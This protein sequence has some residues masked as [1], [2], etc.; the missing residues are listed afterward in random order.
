[1]SEPSVQKS[2]EVHEAN[3]RGD[4]RKRSPSPD[5]SQHK[6]SKSPV[7]EDEPPIDNEKVQLSWCK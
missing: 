1:M 7:K 2:E 3:A 5:Q 6:R 4:K